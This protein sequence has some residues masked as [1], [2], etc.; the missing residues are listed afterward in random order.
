MRILLLGGTGFIGTR[1]V[2]RLLLAGHE[3]AVVHRGHRRVPPGAVSLLAARSEPVPLAAAMDAFGPAAV[4]DMIAYTA[5]G[6]DPVL[7]ALPRQ[8]RRLTIISSGD[9]YAT[10]GAFLGQEAPAPA[11]GPTPETGALR[12]GRYPY[13]DQAPAPDDLRHDYDKILVEARYRDRSP[14]PVTI[15]RLPMVYG[16]GDPQRRVASDLT[17][18]REAPGGTLE[19]HPDEAAWR[20]TRGFVDDIAAAIALATAHPEA[21]GKTYNVGEPDAITT[22]EWL[23]AIAQ[24][25]A[26][27]TRIQEN[28]LAAPSLPARWTVSLVTATDRIRRELGYVEPVGR[29]EAVRLTARAAAT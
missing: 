1:A 14:V 22:R 21:I 18:L 5:T 26:L 2:H 19:L 11:S 29:T 15:L 3:V 7:A 16:P 27:P 25:I 10:Y 12:R 24:A 23:A 13:R 28:P 6:V 9:V 8:L 4:V 17:R 20:C